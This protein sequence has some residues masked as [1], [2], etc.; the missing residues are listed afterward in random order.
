MS[1]DPT[2]VQQPQAR[3]RVVAGL[4]LVEMVGSGGEGEVW[5]ARDERGQ[6]RA[7]KLV[8]PEVLPAPEELGRRGDW[9]TRID[10]PA[11]VRVHRT[12]RLTGSTLEGWGF[13]EMDFVAGEPL[14]AAPADPYALRRLRPL[15]EAL[16]LL[17]A[18]RWSEG[19]PL[20][21]R[22]VKPA[23]LIEQ[24]DGRVVLVDVST[25]RGLDTREATRV[26][27]PLF[28]A[29]EVMT[30]HAGPPADVYSFAATIIALVSGARGAQ[31]A[32]LLAD[33]GRLDLPPTV[34][35]ALH[36]DPAQRPGSCAAVLEA[37]T[38]IAG[39]RGQEPQQ[40]R[41]TPPPTARWFLVLAL[42]AGL[43]IVAPI[44]PFELPEPG[45]YAGVVLLHVLFSRLAG[46][47]WLLTLVPPAAWAWP[48]GARAAPPGRARAWT[49]VTLLGVVTT[50]LA[51]MA[52]LVGT[53][54]VNVGRDLVEEFA[55]LLASALD[56][57]ADGLAALGVDEL[58]AGAAGAG[59]VLFVAALTVAAGRARRLAGVLLRW[60]LLP[61]WV[62]GLLVALV[63]SVLGLLV[64]RV[65]V[66]RL[67]TGAVVSAA[68]FV[69]GWG[70]GRRPLEHRADPRL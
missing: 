64:S 40:L 34:A 55:P 46:A 26:G 61:A 38:T 16:D 63:G 10:H 54:A 66:E 68:A 2:A 50:G 29:P 67:A 14:G 58:A 47:P 11:L 4:R 65:A 5:D 22:D 25:L 9:L 62:L 12:G 48:L 56:V 60:L 15:A 7:L 6:R 42:L 41:L 18:G 59:T 52:P 27:T 51:L 20:V 69:G 21:H 43:V 1:A 19:V 13:V 44:E 30:G 32:D 49:R 70:S 37:G 23:N 28:A 35:Q 3:P 57:I 36:P 45:I 24:D 17:H 33:P 39:P 8:R 31:L 53:A